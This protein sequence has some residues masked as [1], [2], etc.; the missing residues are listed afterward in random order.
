MLN[1]GGNLCQR[2]N[3]A[4]D[5]VVE[6]V[7]QDRAGAVI[8]LDRLLNLAVIK[9][10]EVGELQRCRPQEEEARKDEK[11]DDAPHE[12]SAPMLASTLRGLLNMVLQ[13][14]PPLG[15]RQTHISSILSQ[16]KLC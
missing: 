1:V 6:V 4:L 12:D 13:V 3:G 2:H 11:R 14:G 10:R 15:E 5:V 8:Y 16:E 7:K 9:R